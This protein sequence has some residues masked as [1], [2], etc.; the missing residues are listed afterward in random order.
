MCNSAVIYGSRGNNG[1]IVI[2]TKKGEDPVTL[3]YE[4]YKPNSH[5]IP[6]I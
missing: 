2:Y 4:L 6:N 3:D 5:N 1:V